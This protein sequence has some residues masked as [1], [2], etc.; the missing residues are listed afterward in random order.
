MKIPEVSTETCLPAVADLLNSA[1]GTPV[2]KALGQLAHHITEMV[3]HEVLSIDLAIVLFRDVQT[4][5]A[6]GQLNSLAV[7]NFARLLGEAKD[8]IEASESTNH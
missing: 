6:V 4:I 1:E 5:A 3:G 8:M 7:L 2:E